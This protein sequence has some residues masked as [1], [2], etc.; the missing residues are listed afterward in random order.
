LG[1]AVLAAQ[2]R[3]ARDAVFKIAVI[4]VMTAIR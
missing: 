3:D 1:A 2:E 4:S